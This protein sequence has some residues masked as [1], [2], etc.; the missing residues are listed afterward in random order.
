MQLQVFN[1]ADCYGV[2]VAIVLVLRGQGMVKVP[3]SLYLCVFFQV[4]YFCV[5]ECFVFI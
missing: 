5:N 4:L 3:N 2:N 1:A